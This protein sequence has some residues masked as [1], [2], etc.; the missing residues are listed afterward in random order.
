[1]QQ[2]RSGN[3]TL[4]KGAIDR[5]MAIESADHATVNG[6]IFKT[7]IL[8]LMVFIAGAFSWQ[9][10]ATLS[11]GVTWLL[12]ISSIVALAVGFL[13]AFKPETTPV[14]APIYAIAEGFLLGVI[15]RWASESFGNIV[16]QAIALTGVIFFTTLFLY[17][18]KIVKVTEKFRSVVVIATLG[19]FAYYLIT[20]VLGIFGVNVP[21]VYSNSSWGIA[22]SLAVVFIAA[23]NL[24]LDFNFVESAANNKAPKVFE[25]Y[26]AFG[27]VVTLVWLYLEILRL[28]GKARG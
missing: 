16:V 19:I 27:M 11:G 13:A 14:T 4:S 7:V 10:A 21:L 28:L 3:P 5:V 1:M 23:L 25:W 8:V 2:D 24:L 6:T 9:W 17:Q 20:L 12:G 22:F 18:A 26:G 15:S